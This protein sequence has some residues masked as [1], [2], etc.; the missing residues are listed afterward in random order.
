M[1]IDRGYNWKQT[2]RGY[3]HVYFC[4]SLFS[5][6]GI[7]SNPSNV[8]L[9]ST[10]SPKNFCRWNIFAWMCRWFPY[11]TKIC[12]QPCNCVTGLS[13][14][15]FSWLRIVLILG[16]KLLSIFQRR[17]PSKKAENP[18]PNIFHPSLDFTLMFNLISMM[19]NM[20]TKSPNDPWK[21]IGFL[22]EREWNYHHRFR[23]V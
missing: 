6:L 16:Q 1:A 13:P 5:L 7:A 15:G 4:F 10:S 21:K 19:V 2:F 9:S 8:T 17:K 3:Y 23:F 12:H 14:N 18:I 20:A 11:P 22:S